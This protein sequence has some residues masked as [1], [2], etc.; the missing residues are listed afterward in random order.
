MNRWKTAGAVAAAGGVLAVVG[1]AG[2]TA[3]VRPAAGPATFTGADRAALAYV[4]GHDAGSGPARILA[5]ERDTEHG[6]PVYDISVLAPNGAR[7]TLHLRRSDNQVLS[8]SPSER[9]ATTAAAS[10]DRPSTDTA[11]T[12][13]R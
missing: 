8:V 5:N 3:A 7:L 2:A 9:D 4:R 10:T 13:D 6:V 12:T 1:A 11:R